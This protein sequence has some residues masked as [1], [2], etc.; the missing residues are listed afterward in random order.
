MKNRMPDNPFQ[1]KIWE[2]V[3]K[4]VPEKHWTD[5]VAEVR[6]SP[7]LNADAKDIQ[8][9]HDKTSQLKNLTTKRKA[10]DIRRFIGN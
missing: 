8:A 2:N 1:D 10:P 9:C 5:R 4:I 7:Y 3:K 6:G